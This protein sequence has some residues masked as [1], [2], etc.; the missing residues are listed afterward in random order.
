[1]FTVLYKDKPICIK[2]AREGVGFGEIVFY[3]DEGELMCENECMSADFIKKVL[4]DLV[5][6]A[7]F[8]DAP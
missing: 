7:K 1:M 2:W 3:Y 6:D 5:D 4:C 8:T